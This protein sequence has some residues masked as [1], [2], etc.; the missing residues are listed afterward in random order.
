MQL[1]SVLYIPE[2][3]TTSVSILK[4]N[5]SQNFTRFLI[6]KIQSV[7]LIITLSGTLMN[8]FQRYK[9]LKLTFLAFS[10]IA[11]FYFL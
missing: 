1:V 11:L 5:S 10:H 9:A 6:A 8:L 7:T 2:R 3:I 4:G